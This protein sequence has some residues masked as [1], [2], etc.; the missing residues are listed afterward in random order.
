MKPS[1]LLLIILIELGLQAGAVR[2]DPRLTGA[3]G[4][5]GH[6]L[7]QLKADGTGEMDGAA[8]Q[9]QANAGIVTFTADGLV[10]EV[11]Y[12]IQGEQLILVMSGVPMSL[13]RIGNSD[14][15]AQ[16]N[17]G[18]VEAV[19]KANVPTAAPAADSLSKL[20]LSSAWCSFSYNKVSGAS[21][22]RRVQFLSDGSWSDNSRNEGYS[23]GYG[24]TMASQHDGGANGRWQVMG[25]QLRM[26]GADANLQPVQLQVKTNSN[27]YPIIVADGTEF[28][29]CQ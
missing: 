16:P 12:Q 25:N 24:G 2:A 13:Q 1:I 18:T 10:E 29:Q 26:S 19:V 3:W 9:W 23:S 20:L 5:N 22:Q 11:A 6:V 7:Y 17:T 4:L 21:N 28:S 15:Q 27:G 14:V 8:F